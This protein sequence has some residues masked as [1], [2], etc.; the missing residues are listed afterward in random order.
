MSLHLALKI[1]LNFPGSGVTRKV[2]GV[3]LE[4]MIVGLCTKALASLSFGMSSLG[5]L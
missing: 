3:G 5:D 2:V 4:V 1:T